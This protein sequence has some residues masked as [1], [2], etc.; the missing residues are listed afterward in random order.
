MRKFAKKFEKFIK[1]LIIILGWRKVHGLWMVVVVVKLKI[2]AYD[3]ILLKLR[4]MIGLWWL[5]CSFYL[6][7]LPV[8][9][10]DFGCV[11]CSF[12]ELE[13][14]VDGPCSFAFIWMSTFPCAISFCGA[15]VKSCWFFMILPSS[16]F[17]VLNWSFFVKSCWAAALIKYRR[18]CKLIYMSLNYRK[19]IPMFMSGHNFWFM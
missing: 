9:N 5:E 13:S 10:Y 6:S 1:K 4:S 2:F 8:T 15:D 12:F 11:G 3:I 17:T 19:S 14:T 18:E 16:S 7:S